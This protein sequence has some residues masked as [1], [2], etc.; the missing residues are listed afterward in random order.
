[1]S[2]EVEF[3][4]VWFFV[5]VYYSPVANSVFPIS[6][7]RIERFQSLT[8]FFTISKG[9]VSSETELVE[10]QFF[11]SIFILILAQHRNLGLTPLLDIKIER[12]QS[13]TCFF[14]FSKGFVSSEAEFHAIRFFVF[15]SC[16][17]WPNIVIW[18]YLLAR[19][20]EL[21][22]S[23]VWHVFLPF[24]MG[25]W[26]QKLNSLKSDFLCLFT[27]HLWPTA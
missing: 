15:V 9:F 1:M 10:V 17:S 26:A 5:S 3:V 25:S 7:I 24:L 6:D 11:V 13:L 23:K 12:F 2:W 21:S 22:D 4:E 27:T 16:S 18:A 14:T 8:R 20:S 19:T